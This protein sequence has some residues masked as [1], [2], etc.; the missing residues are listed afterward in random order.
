ML[1]AGPNAVRAYGAP[2]KP[3]RGCK[4]TTISRTGK[5]FQ[6]KISR[7]H[8]FFAKK[9]GREG[10]HIIIYKGTRGFCWGGGQ[11]KGFSTP[12]CGVALNRN[13][14]QEVEATENIDEIENIDTI[15]TIENIETIETIETIEAIEKH[16]HYRGERRPTLRNHQLRLT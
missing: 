14:K 13:D 6:R 5:T 8:V 7:K 16:R 2:F 4:G 10:I 12:Q 1:A 3:E 15:D 9:G 11:R